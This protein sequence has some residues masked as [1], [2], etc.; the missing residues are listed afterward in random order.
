M[1]ITMFN[2]YFVTNSEPLVYS[3]PRSDVRC[4]PY[5]SGRSYS[6]PNN[7]SNNYMSSNY[8]SNIDI[9]ATFQLDDPL[10]HD[11]DSYS[12]YPYDYTIWSPNGSPRCFK[13]RVSANKK[14]RRRTQSINTAF[15]DLR[16]CIPNVPSDTKL[17]KIKTLKLAT[18][19]IEY[20]MDI[21]SKDDPNITPLAFK[22]DITKTRKDHR[23]IKYNNDISPRKNKGR[24]GWP[25]DVWA[26]ELNNKNEN[27]HHQSSDPMTIKTTISNNNGSVCSNSNSPTLSNSSSSTNL[28]INN[29][30]SR[31]KTSQHYSVKKK[32]S[33]PNGILRNRSSVITKIILCN[34]RLS[35]DKLRKALIDVKPLYNS[36][37]NIH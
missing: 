4:H 6:S 18:K 8:Q 21:L 7:N 14:E 11:L 36:K 13:R 27:I 29:I 12:I 24:T 20:L 28:S 3:S 17:S 25:Q 2:D 5:G 15:S 26:S 23:E 1:I 30:V 31:K 35:S 9:D 10:P 22:A 33:R 16:G 37:K 19:Y 32:T 34:E